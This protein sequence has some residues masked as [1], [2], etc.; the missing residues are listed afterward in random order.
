MSTQHAKQFALRVKAAAGA[1]TTEQLAAI[2]PYMLRDFDAAEIVVREF[3]LC[4]NAIDRDNEVFDEPLLADFAR[5][6]P[7]KGVFVVHPT[8]WRSDGGPGEG[9]CFDARVERMSQDAART[10]LREPMLTWPP[11]R[12]DASL[13][14][15]SAY[16]VKTSENEAL[17]LKMDAGIVGDCSVGF[18]ATGPLPIR[19]NAGRELEAR[20]YV[21][22]GEAHEFSLVWL[23]AQTGA[24]AIKSFTPPTEPAMT[25][26]QIAALQQENTTLKAAQTAGN[27]TVT[28]MAALKTALGED[29]ALLD[30][31]K[32]LASA[33]K[34]AKDY[35]TALVE[36]VV[37]GERQ[38]GLVADDEASV[39]AH[40]DFLAVMPLA[41]LEARAKQCAKQAP[42]GGR[43][44]PTDPNLGAP[45]GAKSAT[46]SV[47]SNTLIV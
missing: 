10:L 34:A 41:L 36:D 32:A 20:R 8:S 4:H 33:V 12:T 39:K 5:S 46:D 42:R 31:P 17:L 27:A 21:S 37:A 45:K 13:L 23:G 25:P 22:P 2:R 11:D 38:M 18:C 47:L 30:D 14:F 24:R 1:P 6:L 26:E 28:A 3:V 7:G 16:F 35:R 19:D 29:A 43:V 15:A 44:T 9:R 40:R